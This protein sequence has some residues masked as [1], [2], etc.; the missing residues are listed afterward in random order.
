MIILIDKEHYLI[1]LQN[2]LDEVY[3]ETDYRKISIRALSNKVKIQMS[4]YVME[5]YGEY[6]KDKL[7]QLIKE[8]HDLL[9]ECLLE[10]GMNK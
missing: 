7:P 6:H 10:L 4:E 5:R 1:K 3:Q 8:S 9:E 2:V